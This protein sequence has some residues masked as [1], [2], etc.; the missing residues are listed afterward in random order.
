MPWST[1][2]GGGGRKGGSGGPWGNSPDGGGSGDPPDF[3]DM[4]KRGKERFREAMPGTGGGGGGLIGIVALVALLAAAFY[5][6]TVRIN[7]DELGIVTRFGK[8]DRTLSPGLNFRLPPPVEEVFAPKVTVV[9]QLQIGFK[10]STDP[11]NNYT[12][13]DIPEESLMLTG[14]E[15]IVDV[16]F[17][18]FWLIK[19]PQDF[20]FNIKDGREFLDSG[21]AQTVHDVAESAMR[22]VVGKND[23]QPILTQDRVKTEDS[24]RALMQRTLDAYKAGIEVSQVQLQKVDPPGEVINSFRDVQ[25]AKIDFERAQNEAQSYS[26]KVIPEARGDAERIRQEAQAY[27]EKIEAEAIGQADR[28]TQVYNAYKLSPEITRKRIY[29][30][31]MQRVFANMSKIIIDQKGQGVVPYLPLGDLGKPVQPAGGQ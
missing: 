23:I 25:A 24:V 3:E 1:Q 26:N 27:R 12:G 5:L 20:L 18:V 8:Y 30:E 19:N 10:G 28:F 2:G 15:N 9:N 4:L 6:F 7:P 21:Q 14:D 29:L 13:R 17:T 11:R 31:T 16:D 22:E